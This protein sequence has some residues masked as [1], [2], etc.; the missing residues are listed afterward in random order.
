MTLTPE[1]E[2][3]F[4]LDGT[5]VVRYAVIDPNL[6]PPSHFNVVAAGIPI[7]LAVVRRLIV[8]EDL[9]KGG[10]YLMHCDDEWMTVAAEVFRDA[11]AAQ[12]SADSRYA[13]V[14]LRWV[15]YRELTESERREVETTRNFLR[16]LAGEYPDE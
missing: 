13:G 5:H 16:E 4:L 12:R 7:D 8:A 10:A 6:P 11:D 2:P 3:P 14:P 15:H 1:P 9:V